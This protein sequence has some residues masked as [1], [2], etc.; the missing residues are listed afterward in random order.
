MEVSAVVQTE[1]LKNLP[2]VIGG[3]VLL[4]IL[5]L[6]CFYSLEYKDESSEPQV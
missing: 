4:L 2:W 6:N 1:L 5:S 3:I